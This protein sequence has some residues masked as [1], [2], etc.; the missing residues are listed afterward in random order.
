MKT[1]VAL[2]KCAQYRQE[3]I[4]PALDKVFTS[5]GGLKQFIPCGGTV[6]I[7]PNLLTD[8]SPDKAATTHPEIVRAVIRLVRQHGGNPV[9]GDSPAGTLQIESV[10]EKTGFRALCEEEKV[11]FIFFEKEPCVSHDYRGMSLAIAKSALEADLIINVPKFKT[12]SYTLFT[13]A[14]KNLY[15]LLPGY[16]KILLHKTFPNPDQFGDCLAFIYGI[17]KPALTVCDAVTAMEGSGPS[18]GTPCQLGLLAASAD[19][20]ALDTAMCNLLKINPNHVGYLNSLRRTG[21]GET[22]PKNIELAGDGNDFKKLRPIKQPGAARVARFIPRRL[23]KFI[24][25]YVWIAPGFLE[26]C[27]ACGRCV[28]SCPTHALELNSARHPILNRHKCIACCCCH[29]TCPENAIKMT[30]S[31]LLSIF[32]GN[33]QID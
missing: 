13:N 22:D 26:S 10:L 29:E 1:V 27:T 20:V 17:A 16:Q 3:Y 23:F 31:P 12:H 6:L 11:K 9:I 8:R 32:A 5:I 2:A 33:R 28:R 4:C 15:G 25:P 7:K 14:V 30:C 21:I 24:E 18:C 19:G